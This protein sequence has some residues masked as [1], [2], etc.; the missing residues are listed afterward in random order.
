MWKV[1]ETRVIQK[2]IGKAPNEIQ[3]EYEAWKELVRT[4]GPLSL[5]EFPGY[6]DHALKGEWLGARSSS[7]N[8]KWRV[9]Y[10]VRAD[11]IEVLV[12]NLTPHDY[13]RK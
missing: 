11:Q 3:E 13:R 8:I 4:S 12:L 5:R 2:I 10:V 1:S 9:I 6:R 7:L